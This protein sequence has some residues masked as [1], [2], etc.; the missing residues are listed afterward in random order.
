L[1][2]RQR[3]TDFRYQMNFGFSFRFGSIFNNV[4]NPRRGV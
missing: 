4:V 1:R 3:E 2:R